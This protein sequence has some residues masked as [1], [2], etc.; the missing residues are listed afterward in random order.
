VLDANNVEKRSKKKTTAKKLIPN[1]KRSNVGRVF[2]I[3][4]LVNSLENK[5]QPSRFSNN[6]LPR[7]PEGTTFLEALSAHKAESES[8][9]L[10]KNTSKRSVLTEGN[11][12]SAWVVEETAAA[13]IKSTVL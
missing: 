12:I 1:R 11:K 3:R 4:L 8:S 9:W 7:C 5:A 2:V 13:E 6:A 10:I